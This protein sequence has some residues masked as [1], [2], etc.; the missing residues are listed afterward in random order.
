MYFSLRMLC[1]FWRTVSHLPVGVGVC[2]FPS[3]RF[4]YLGCV[5]ITLSIVYVCRFVVCNCVCIILFYVCVLMYGENVQ[6]GF[7]GIYLG[8]GHMSLM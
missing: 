2:I 6:G 8:S 7:L 3:W 5:I 4:Q 1:L